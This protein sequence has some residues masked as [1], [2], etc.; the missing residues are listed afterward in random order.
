[1]TPR[2]WHRGGRPRQPARR[3]AQDP[4]HPAGAATG[5]GLPGPGLSL[6]RVHQW[7]PPS[8]AR[9][10][11]RR[12]GHGRPR[13]PLDVPPPDGTALAAAPPPLP[14]A[15]HDAIEHRHE[16]LGLDIGPAT[17]IPGWYGERL[18]LGSVLDTLFSQ[19]HCSSPLARS[20]RERWCRRYKAA[21]SATTPPASGSRWTCRRPRRVGLCLDAV[22]E[23]CGSAHGAPRRPLRLPSRSARYCAPHSCRYR[24]PRLVVP[25]AASCAMRIL[26]RQ[27][28]VGLESAIRPERADRATPAPIGQCPASRFVWLRAMRPRSTLGTACPAAS[29]HARPTTRESPSDRR[30]WPG[31]LRR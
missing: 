13:Q 14:T 29:H 11:V 31:G 23:L 6:P 5:V 7:P 2:W 25:S 24:V 26:N 12:G 16:A 15:T 30:P 18:H 3:R 19:Q 20:H 17:A 27:S 22:A 4:D 1:M 28:R 8:R 9:G 21:R 10:W